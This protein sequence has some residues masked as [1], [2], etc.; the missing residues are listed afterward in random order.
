MKKTFVILITFLIFGVSS[1][2]AETWIHEGNPRKGEVAADKNNGEYEKLLEYYSNSDQ[3]ATDIAELYDAAPPEIK[4]LIDRS[5]E[6]TGSDR[7]V[8]EMLGIKVPA[9]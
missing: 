1:S 6:E 2:S 8:M 4:E 3:P 7:A 9:E 5:Y